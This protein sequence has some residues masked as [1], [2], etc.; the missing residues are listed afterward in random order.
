MKAAF[1]PWADRS[2]DEAWSTPT[3]FEPNHAPVSFPV[4][5]RVS[6]TTLRAALVMAP[7]VSSLTRG[8]SSFVARGGRSARRTTTLSTAS[9][10]RRDA[11]A[12]AASCSCVARSLLRLGSGSELTTVSDPDESSSTTIRVIGRPG[13][14]MSTANPATRTTS[15]VPFTRV[16]RRDRRTL[17][18]TKP[19]L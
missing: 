12:S 16:D 19:A 18:G 6:T 10:W 14:G 8:P 4:P 2:V 15:S 13:D 3:L 5:M 1:T 17:H 11:T 9:P 7:S